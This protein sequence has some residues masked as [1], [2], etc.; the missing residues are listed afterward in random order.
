MAMDKSRT[1]P[2][3]KTMIV[4]LAVSF[5]LGIGGFAGAGLSSCS[6]NTSLL[7]GGTSTGTPGASADTTA[8]IQAINL[9]FTPQLSTRE[10]SITADPKNYDLL[11]AQGN[12]YYDWASQISSIA[13]TISPETAALW[14]NAATFYQRALAVKP[15]D[16]NVATDCA[17]ALFYAGKTDDAIKLAEQTRKDNPTFSPV[18]FNLGIFYEN[19]SAADGKAKAIAAY[20][21]Y[22][23]LDPNGAN[24]ANAKQFLSQLGA[25]ATATGTGN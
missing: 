11:V 7:P 10:A 15:G 18:V 20:Q 2:F 23:K 22:L 12:D 5:V 4:I 24:A 14:G 19:S 8:Q 9:R 1:S 6:A 21:D 17:I 16:P 3:V 25:S 13:K